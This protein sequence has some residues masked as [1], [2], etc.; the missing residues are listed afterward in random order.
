MAQESNQKPVCLR[1]S[2]DGA[3]LGVA[4]ASGQAA[5]LQID[6]GRT[7]LR[8]IHTV[9]ATGSTGSTSRLNHMAWHPTSAQ[10]AFVGTEK[11]VDVWDVRANRPSC[12]ITTSG[13]NIYADWSPDGKYLVV[14]NEA[15]LVSVLDVTAGRVISKVKFAHEVNELAWSAN[16]DHIML[17]HGGPACGGLTVIAHDAEKGALS[18]AYESHAHAAPGMGLRVDP[19]YRYLA[20]GSTDM[21]V[22]LWSLEDL[23]VE[24]TL[25]DLDNTVSNMSFSGDGSH[26]ALCAD[27]SDTVHIYHARMGKA[28]CAPLQSARGHISVLDWHPRSPLIA[29]GGERPRQPVKSPHQVRSFARPKASLIDHLQLLLVP[30]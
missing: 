10:F 4:S 9:Q 22:S 3:Y 29:V 24:H 8:D 23:V 11:N 13:R 14:G 16:S 27:G 30:L 1:W 19:T 28:S 2:S 26:V 17:A 6:A 18:L 25:V 7:N 5:I 12:K 20:L 21:S 15:N